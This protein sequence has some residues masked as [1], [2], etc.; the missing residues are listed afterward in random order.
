MDADLSERFKQAL[1]QIKELR[2][3]VSELNSTVAKKDAIIEQALEQTKELK[4]EVFELNSTVAKKDAILI[5]QKD[6]LLEKRDFLLKG[7]AVGLGGIQVRVVSA[8]FQVANFQSTMLNRIVSEGDN[9]T[10]SSCR[11]HLGSVLVR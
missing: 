7:D 9:L 11:K 2:G 8:L 6:A 4:G 5:E 10:A 1:E 3:E